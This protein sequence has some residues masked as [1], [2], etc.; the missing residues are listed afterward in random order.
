[1]FNG[2]RAHED[3]PW[4]I[5]YRAL[6][7][8]TMAEI[9]AGP[10]PLDPAWTADLVRARLADPRALPVVSTVAGGAD[11]IA[12]QVAEE[13]EQFS[14]AAPSN[15]KSP[16]T[17]VKILLLQQIDLAWWNEVLEF[18]SQRDLETNPDLVDLVA[19]R[20]AGSLAFTFDVLDDGFASRVRRYVDRRFRPRRSPGTAG[21]STTHVRP[22]MITVL[23]H[24]AGEF[25]AVAPAGTPKLHLNSVSRSMEQQRWLRS[26]GYSALIP[27]AHC[28]GWAADLEMN[29]F[30]VFGARDALASLLLE[31]RDH[32]LL[33]VIDE[34]QAWH[35]CPNPEAL[36]YFRE[37]D[38]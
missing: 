7:D 30:E 8:E 5:A 3:E 22:D 36:R 28:R 4:V 11:S 1:M 6:V 16:E 20:R 26:L 9:A 29:W 31:Y 19:Q 18:E 25:A 10:H 35:I 34:G 2:W 38:A 33:N 37:A 12:R 17:M 27:S 23:N 24:I 15:A 32:G 14:S 13:T 21:L